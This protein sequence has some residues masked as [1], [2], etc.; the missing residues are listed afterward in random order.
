MAKKTARKTKAKPAERPEAE[1]TAVGVECS[2]TMGLFSTERGI[3]L[4]TIDGVVYALVDAA[5]VSVSGLL[6]QGWETQGKV[7]AFVVEEMEDSVLVDLPKPTLM[8]GPRITIPRS[9][10]SW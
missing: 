3:A 1:A 10:V 2:V 5:N 4:R 8:G 6:K 7:R 9:A